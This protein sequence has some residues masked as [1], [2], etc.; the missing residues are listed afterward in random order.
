[1]KKSIFW[2]LLAVVLSFAACQEPEVLLPAEANKG[3]NNL[4]VYPTWDGY[5]T[6]DASGFT[7]KIDYEKRVI[8][9]QVP[10]TLPVESDNVQK[11]ENYKK[12]WVQFNLD[13]NATLEPKL[14]TIDLT[15]TYKVTLTD[16]KKEQSEWTIK[17]AL[18]KSSACDIESFAIPSLGLTAVIDKSSAT[19]SLIY[20]EQLKNVFAEV[21]VSPHA[22]IVPDP[23]TTAFW[24]SPDEP[25]K[26][27]VIAQDGVTS[28][29]WTLQQTEPARVEEG[30]R[31][32]SGKMLWTTK[33]SA[34][35][36]AKLDMTT[37]IAVTDDYV[38]L[39]TRG[40]DPIV[41]DAKKGTTVG[42]MSLGSIKGATSS[43]YMTSDHKGHIVINN[44][45]PDDGGVFRVW[46]MRDINSTPELF[47]EYATTDVYGDHISVWG[48]VYGD[49]TV[50]A[51]YCG[52][53]STGSTSTLTWT[54]K[55]GQ[56]VSMQPYWCQISGVG[57]WTNGDAIRLGTDATA[58]FLACGYSMNKLTWVDGATNAALNYVQGT[59]T[60]N[61][62]MK[63]VDAVPFNGINYVAATM[64]TF[65]TWGVAGGMW[66]MEA[67]YPQT[68]SGSLELDAS[69]DP[70]CVVYGLDRGEGGY[71]IYGG[72]ANDGTNGNAIQDVKLHVTKDGYFMYAYFMFCNGYVGCIQFD[73]IAQ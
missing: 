50:Q 1:M 5:H 46:R 25:K 71:G 44:R 10:Y 24:C 9:I 35:G 42:T 63:A 7:S 52:W 45:V 31:P 47:I 32:E 3:I 20:F 39:N 58:D 2:T 40:E 36:V 34:A 19:A 26:F 59:L 61:E 29:E 53:T 43:Y 4:T 68:F 55:D 14:T 13:D 27:T 28:R 66:V 17:A 22:K 56:T 73:C 57:G 48:D 51:A 11:L 62:G 16:Q 64:E 70:D 30:I 65:F 67:K 69:L 23:A 8:T 38:I 54:V 12:V 72:R 60:G 18:A 6:A 33:L 49:A 41:L 21:V 15:Q 37:G